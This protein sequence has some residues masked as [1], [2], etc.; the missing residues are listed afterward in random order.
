MIHTTKFFLL[1]VL[2]NIGTLR[3]NDTIPSTQKIYLNDISID[4]VINGNGFGMQ[5][6]PSMGIRFGKRTILKTGPLF[7]ASDWK[8]TGYLLSVACL[9]VHENASY[10]GRTNLAA[11]V[12][13]GRYNNASLSSAS[14]LH[15]QR[16][17][18]ANHN[19]EI[20]NFEN[21][22]FSGWEFSAGLSVSYRMR[23]GFLLK[24]SAGAAYTNSNQLKST[25]IYT[26]REN[27]IVSLQ[28]S[29][30]IGWGFGKFISEKEHEEAM[31]KVQLEEE[32]AENF[33]E[34]F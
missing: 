7:N 24:S 4:G 28:L 21:L 33:R 10:N 31:R 9:L 30:G 8:P 11:N 20:Y 6:N 3:A 25:E 34:S 32:Y 14:I 29:V 5:Y 17:A 1:I 27:H 15:E 2:L 22:S 13:I 12:T 19:K 26:T 16:I 18:S 23:C